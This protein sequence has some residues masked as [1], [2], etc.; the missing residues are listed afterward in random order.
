MSNTQRSMKLLREEGYFVW[1][2]ETWCAF[3]KRK[4][5]LLGFADLL[6]LRSKR[7]VA[8]QTTSRANL[9]ARR[10]KIL[11]AESYKHW[12]EAGNEV[13]LHGWFKKANRWQVKTEAL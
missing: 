1:H 3:T 7:T 11:N 10:K 8:V 5:D 13:L 6:A 4:K 12:K 9:S 2:C